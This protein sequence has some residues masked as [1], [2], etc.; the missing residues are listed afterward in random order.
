MDIPNKW[1]QMKLNSNR[2]FLEKNVSSDP[3]YFLIQTA[4]FLRKMFHLTPLIFL[5][6]CLRA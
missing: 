1:G 5:F 4:P 6:C 3:T 2:T